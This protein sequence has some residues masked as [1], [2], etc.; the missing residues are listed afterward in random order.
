MQEE[1]TATTCMWSRGPVAGKTEQF[2]SVWVDKSNKKLSSRT[3]CCYDK[4]RSL[5]DDM[6]KMEAAMTHLEQT[7]TGSLISSNEFILTI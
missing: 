7:K 4:A 3:K 2:L 5:F 1:K 6:K